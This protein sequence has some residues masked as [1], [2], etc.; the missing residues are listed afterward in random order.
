[1]AGTVN[2][3]KLS[4]SHGGKNTDG[5]DIAASDFV[6]WELSLNGTSVLN[7]PIG[8]TTTQGNYEA[9]IPMLNLAPGAYSATLKLVTKQGKSVDSNTVQFEIKKV[10]APPF[11]LS[12][13]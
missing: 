6:A 9:P 10:P 3:A 7:V 13:A 12:A 4:W 11:N 5:S 8:W 1:M 2:P